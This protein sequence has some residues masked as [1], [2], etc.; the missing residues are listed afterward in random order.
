MLEIIKTKNPK[1]N[2][3]VLLHINS[4]LLFPIQGFD[5]VDSKY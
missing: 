1:I 3:K 4:H 2:K 5:Y